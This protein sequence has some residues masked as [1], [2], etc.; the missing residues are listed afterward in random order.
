MSVTLRWRGGI[1]NRLHLSLA[2][3]L[4]TILAYFLL[5]WTIHVRKK[6][7]LWFFL[8][9]SLERQRFITI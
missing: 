1:L 8:R 5:S 7:P 6:N 4:Y 2:L 3:A 9:F